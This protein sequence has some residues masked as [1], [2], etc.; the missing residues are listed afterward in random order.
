M[1]VINANP[2]SMAF[3]YTFPLMKF[4]IAV[5]SIF[6]QTLSQILSLEIL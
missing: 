3:L 2:I 1:E 6:V 4:W 5:A